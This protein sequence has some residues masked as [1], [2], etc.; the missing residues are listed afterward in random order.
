VAFWS[1]WFQ[2][3]SLESRGLDSND[4]SRSKPP[5]NNPKG[6]PSALEHRAF[7]EKV[8]A[9]KGSSP[10]LFQKQH[11][12]SDESAI[13]PSSASATDDSV[14]TLFNLLH[15]PSHSLASDSRA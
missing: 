9:V 7:E 6:S 14:S 3:Q 13:S 11:V 1:A 10:V 8:G 2:K 12:S 5:I 4:W 15:V